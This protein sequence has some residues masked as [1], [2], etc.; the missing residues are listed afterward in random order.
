MS[1]LRV[2]TQNLHWPNT[3]AEK[4]R[5]VRKA[6]ERLDVVLYQEAYNVPLQQI[7][8]SGWGV[9]QLDSGPGNQDVAIAWRKSRVDVLR[10]NMHFIGYMN[11][12]GNKKPKTFKI[13][14]ITARIDDEY[15]VVFGSLHWPHGKYRDQD[16]DLQ[17][18]VVA[19]TKTWFND[20]SADRPVVLGGDWNLQISGNPG[21]L[22]NT[23]GGRFHEA[24]GD[25]G[26]DGFLIDGAS[27]RDMSLISNTAMESDHPVVIT[28]IAV[29]TNA[30]PAAGSS[31]PTQTT[32]DPTT[33][34]GGGDEVPDFGDSED[35]YPATPDPIVPPPDDH[36]VFRRSTIRNRWRYFAERLN[37]DG[38]GTLIEPEIPLIDPEIEDVLS[39]PG[40]LS[41]K[42]APEVARLVDSQGRPVFQEW[43]TA[44][45]AEADGE[46]HGGGILT[47]SSFNGSEW[48]IECTG[49]TGYAKD[50][51]Y[52][53]S[54]AYF[55]NT[56]TLDIVRYIW[57]H[58]QSQ[59][60]GNIGL[61]FDQTKS[62]LLVGSEL[63][64]EEYDPEGGP[65]GLTLQSQAYKLRWYQ[66]HDLSS[67]IDGLAEDT[68][69]DYHER[70]FWDGDVVRHYVDF[71][72]PRLGRRRN[73]L[74][75][76][77]GENI[78]AMPTLERDG[79]EYADEVYM[80][81]A[82]EGASMI[83]GHAFSGRTRL[84]RPTVL[85][86]SSIRRLARANDKARGE[87][88]WRRSLDDI[89]SVSVR[90]TPHAPIGAV[91]VGDEIYIAGNLGWVE[92]GA[93]F[94]VLSRT[95]KPQSP[96]VMGLELAR[97]DRLAS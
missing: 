24:S 80:L 9:F 39:G 58:I 53:G 61:E 85:T 81:G 76:V 62:R 45:Y 57:D 59:D 16:P 11:A 82:G 86:D 14:N 47:H 65:G 6:Q 55:V 93:W 22:A 33:P 51:P 18:Q 68:P 12:S 21:N 89:S 77:L 70:H 83:R 15:T 13:A 17:A 90:N 71:G 37:G 75:F 7:L 3:D 96:D 73:S 46:I 29:Q 27:V 67:N 48:D 95:L 88:Q 8:G 97:S 20:K 87:L 4:A 74:R 54:G 49:F 84:R 26:I 78:F 56:D 34:S 79:D 32:D 25:R 38:T 94:R 43:S 44:I 64:S 40:G 31:D 92:A 69:F 72:V 50:M 1:S 5:D 28:R 63:A 91:N 60:G 23:T 30:A 10:K 42:L 2:G 19:N 66:D 36:F 52:T 41:G 35:A